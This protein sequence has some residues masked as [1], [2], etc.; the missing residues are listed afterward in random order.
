M[1]MTEENASSD[2]L[3]D[4]LRSMQIRV[5]AL[6][7]RNERVETDKAWETSKTRSTLIAAITY[8]ICLIVFHL[9]GSPQAFRNA[10]IPTIGYYLSTQ[11][12]PI[13]RAWW[14]RRQDSK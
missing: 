13:A 6:E 9:I 1:T 7:Q 14:Q 8:L 5:A 12:I 2:K 10:L 3:L 4:E 11:S